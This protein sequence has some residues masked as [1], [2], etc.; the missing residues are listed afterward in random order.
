M[1]LGFAVCAVIAPYVTSAIAKYTG[2][3]NTVFILTTVL[4]LVGVVLTLVTK[5]YVGTVLAKIH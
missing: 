2:S 3:Y 4:L 5:R 1:Y